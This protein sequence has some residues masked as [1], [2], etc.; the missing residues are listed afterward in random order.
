MYRSTI[1]FRLDSDDA[2]RDDGLGV[3][4]DLVTLSPG[5]KAVECKW[6]YIVKLN[7]DE[8]LAHL[9][10]RLVVKRYSGV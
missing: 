4:W 7:S 5:K 2:G 10:T 1:S 6:V 3:E 8:F 9:K